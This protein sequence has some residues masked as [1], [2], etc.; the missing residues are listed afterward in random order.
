MHSVFN[1]LVAP[2]GSRTT[3][4]KKI[5]GQT[6]LL[7]TDLQNHEYSNRIGKLLS[8]PLAN[9]YNE[10]REGDDV[11]VHHNIF[12]R[13]R[14]VRGQEKNSK[15]YLSE[16]IYLVQPDQ[17][18]A[19]KRNNEWKALEGFVFVMPIKET[20]MFSLDSE[21]PLIGIVKYSNGEFKEDDLIG[22]RPNSEYEFIIEGQRLYRVPT[23][24][25]TIKYEH[26]GNEEEYNPG[27]AQ[28]S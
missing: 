20:K 22:F 26:Q 24:S 2:K 16:D 10:L 18:Y 13:F 11:I 19:Y 28:S 7:N 8:L 12:R 1:Y 4:V 5:E 6:L 27:W 15:N 17:I 3:G 14:D 9:V 21:K 25:I 23:N